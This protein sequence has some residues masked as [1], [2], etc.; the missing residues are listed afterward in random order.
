MKYFRKELFDLLDASDNTVEWNK[1]MDQYWKQV[2]ALTPRIEMLNDP[3]AVEFFTKKS[4]HDGGLIELRIKEFVT[5]FKLQI[6]VKC[7]P[8][9]I[10]RLSYAGI[11][12]LA[13]DFPS[14]SPLIEMD[15]P[16]RFGDWLYDELTAAD[17]THLSHE[18][19][20]STGAMIHVIFNQF[21]LTR[22]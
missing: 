12:K 17:D 4:L 14:D 15:T 20:F 1:A 7:Y 11:K 8:H 16:T 3:L 9:E 18:I 13:L 21:S 6:T 22:D 5:K 19:M 2:E 10:W